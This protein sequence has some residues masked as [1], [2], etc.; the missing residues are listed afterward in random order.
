M[1]LKTGL[2]IISENGLGFHNSFIMQCNK[3]LSPSMGMGMVEIK[4][5]HL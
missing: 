3:Q 4:L 2:Y 1:K 5:D